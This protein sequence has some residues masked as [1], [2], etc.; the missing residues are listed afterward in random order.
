[1]TYNDF[2]SMQRSILDELNIPYVWTPDSFSF[3][4]NPDYLGVT[5]QDDILESGYIL[6]FQPNLMVQI[7]TGSCIRF[8]DP[9]VF[10]LPGVEQ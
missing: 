10:E 7:D 4:T 2:V 9:R 3:M 1:M 8:M 5:M 6:L